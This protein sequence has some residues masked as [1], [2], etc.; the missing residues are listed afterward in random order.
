MMEGNVPEEDLSHLYYA[1][2]NTV[3]LKKYPFQI[4]HNRVVKDKLIMS[5]CPAIMKR[6][7]TMEG[8]LLDLAA[9]TGGDS[10]KWKLGLLKNVVGIEIVRESVEIAR[11]TYMSHKGAK[12]NTTYIWGDSG[13]LIFPNYDAALDGENKGLL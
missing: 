6:S 1:M 3:R 9:G 10:L 8:S 12:P 13:K 5:V 2:N 4:F 7:H 11:T